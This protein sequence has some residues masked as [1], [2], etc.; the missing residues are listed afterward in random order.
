MFHVLIL[1]H[2]I[3]TEYHISKWRVRNY[4]LNTGWRLESLIKSCSVMISKEQGT[5]NAEWQVATRSHAS[6]RRPTEW[7]SASLFLEQSDLHKGRRLFIEDWINPFFQRSPKEHDTSHSNLIG[8]SALRIPSMREMTL[9]ASGLFRRFL[10]FVN[11]HSKIHEVSYRGSTYP[12]RP[13]SRRG[14]QLHTTC[15]RV[16][17]SRVVW[18]DGSRCRTLCID[19]WLIDA[20]SP[21]PRFSSPSRRSIRERQWDADVVIQSSMPPRP[22]V[23]SAVCPVVGMSMI[24]SWMQRILPP[25]PTSMEASL[26]KGNRHSRWGQRKNC[27]R[28][29]VNWY[30]NPLRNLLISFQHSYLS[31]ILV[32]CSLHWMRAANTAHNKY[33]IG[34]FKISNRLRTRA[35]QIVY[36]LQISQ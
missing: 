31:S 15:W 13:V 22:Q 10:S 25:F 7:P 12:S 18:Q 28:N 2:E 30:N 34:C 20:S 16:G 35:C 1:N 6:S 5:G 9:D 32:E 4:K 8:Q 21:S 11:G 33:V 36:N 3:P 27:W 26:V 23:I 29:I 14:R 19:G 17:G 24:R